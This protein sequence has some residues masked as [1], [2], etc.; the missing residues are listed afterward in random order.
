M[1]LRL[2]QHDTLSYYETPSEAEDT[3]S[4]PLNVQSRKVQIAPKLYLFGLGGSVPSFQDGKKLWD[5]F[6]YT[7]DENFGETVA[8]LLDPILE[9]DAPSSGDSYIF[10]THN[11]PNKSSK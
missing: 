8:K 5:G 6:P 4:F 7:S 10:M 11:G 3:T 1:N 2:I 9:E